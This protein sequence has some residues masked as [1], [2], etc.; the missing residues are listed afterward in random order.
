MNDIKQLSAHLVG[1]K[2]R[3]EHLSKSKLPI[4]LNESL[5]DILNVFFE[6]AFKTDEYFKF[7][8]QVDLGMNEVYAY[9][10]KIF[11]DPTDFHEQSINLAQYLFEVSV[12]PK[13]KA[14]EFYIVYFENCNYKGETVDAIGLFKTENKDIFLNVKTEDHFFDIITNKGININKLDKSCIIFNTQEEDGFI[15]IVKDKTNDIGAQYWFDDFLH[16][17]QY[18][19]AYFYTQKTMAVFKNYIDDRFPEEFETSKIDQADY[20]NRTMEYFKNAEEFKSDEFENQVLQQPEVIESFQNFKSDLEYEDN[21]MLQDNFA[22]AEKAVKKQNS[23]YKSILKLDK[24]FHIYVHG[25]RSKIERGED[26]VGKYY[27]IYF[28][29][30]T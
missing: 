9:V 28:E 8:H 19:D 3:H 10:K 29:E 27:K 22:I 26:S 17:K 2:N 7:F 5:T 16:V 6:N 20:L 11:D 23:V 18:E 1:N 15:T 21:Q 24:N 14:G 30:E 13:I 25:D 4:E 12:H